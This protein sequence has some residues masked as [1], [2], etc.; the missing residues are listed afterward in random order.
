L[1]NLTNL[2]NLEKIDCSYNLLEQLNLSDCNKLIEL[3]CSDNQTTSLI[4][5]NNV[6]LTKLFCSNNRLED[7]NFLN[8]L[9]SVRMTTLYLISN[10]LISENLNLLNLL[11]NLESLWI[12]SNPLIG[13]LQSFQKLIRLKKLHINQTNLTTGLEYLPLSLE[14]FYCWETELS[15]QLIIMGKLIFLVITLNLFKIEKNLKQI[16]Y[17]EIEQVIEELKI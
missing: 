4:L 7:L 16:Y 5:K 13:S 15:E 6:S 9:N 12:G 2:V 17:E 1:L 11:P 3:D 8:Q 14:E 10:N